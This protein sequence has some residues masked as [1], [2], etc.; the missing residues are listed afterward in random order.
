MNTIQKF[1]LLACTG[2]LLS[3]CIDRIS[4]ARCESTAV[5]ATEVRADTVVT[6]TGLRWIEGTPGIGTELAWCK[7]VAVHYDAY[8]LDGGKFDSSRD[9]GRPLLFVPGY[10]ALIDGFEQGVVGMRTGGT[11]RLI[12]PPQLGY[13]SEP[14]RDSAGQI[15]IPGN[16]TLVFDLEVI[17]IA[18]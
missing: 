15:I 3:G 9:D 1:L 13:G 4:E 14:L 8:L 12:V 6:N 17:E 7:A 10:S 11:R 16:S 18:P 2:G 5:Q